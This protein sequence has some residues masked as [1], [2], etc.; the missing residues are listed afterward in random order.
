V[1]VQVYVCVCECF[2]ESMSVCLGESVC[3]CKCV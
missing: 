2:G 3:V 1:H